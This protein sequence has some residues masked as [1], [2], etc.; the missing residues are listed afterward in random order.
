MLVRAI[1][2]A[3]PP[4][5]DPSRALQNLR[6]ILEH[7]K[8]DVA[9]HW[10]LNRLADDHVARQFRELLAEF[11]APYTELPLRLEQYAQAPFN[12]VVEDHG[13]DR[14]HEDPRDD[15]EW[16]KHQDINAIYAS[17]NR[18]ALGINVARNV[19]LDIARQSGARWLLPW[20]QTCFLTQEAWGQIKRDLDNAAPDQKYFMSFMDRLTEENDVIFSPGFKVDPWEEPQIIFRN[21]SVERFDEQLRYG[22]RDKAALLIRLQVSGVWNGWG[23]ARGNSSALLPIYPGTLPELMQYPVPGT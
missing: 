13:V 18:Y 12:V 6:F 3:L 22:Q 10:V 17:K 5:H 15:D 16:T 19:M 14:V 1:G 2:N 9:T 11:D 20:D 21:D 4:R 8:L 23:G 7:E